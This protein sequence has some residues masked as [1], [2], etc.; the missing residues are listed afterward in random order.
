M[1][2]ILLKIFNLFFNKKE[3]YN[4]FNLDIP[5]EKDFLYEELFWWV[6]A[7]LVKPFPKD[8]LIIQNQWISQDTQMACGCFWLTHISNAQNIIEYDNFWKEYNQLQARDL[9]LDYLKIN[10][11]AR[12]EWSTL[13]N[14]L[15]RF[16]DSGLIIWYTKINSIEEAKKAIDL[17]QYIYSWALKWD[18]N[19]VKTTW[20]FKSTTW[21]TYWHLFTAWVWYNDQGFIAI[22][23]YW[24]K[25]WYF[26]I[27]YSEWNNLYSKYAIIDNENKELFKIYT[28][29]VNQIKTMDLQWY[30]ELYHSYKN[31]LWD[32]HQLVKFIQ[33]IWKKRWLNK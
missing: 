22:N 20:V 1:K 24:P 17:W 6:E 13:Q 28:D 21:K 4:D 7:E 10:P 19:H 15:K 31:K 5:D 11:K 9:W 8:K 3:E 30:S 16:K 18:W 2:N 32:Q 14:W 33:S 27:P 25:N 26:T 23:S 29:L 12:Y